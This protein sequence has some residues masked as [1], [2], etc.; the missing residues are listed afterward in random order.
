MA[1]RVTETEVKE[2][3]DTSVNT[4]AFITAANMVVNQNLQNQG[5]SNELLK[6]IER[7]LAAHFVAIRDPREQSK[8]VGSS[9]ANYQGQTGLGLDHTSYGQQVKVLDYTGTLG[10]LGF[11]RASIAVVS[12]KDSNYHYSGE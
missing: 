2:I 3:I 11:K 12:E 6:E 10:N 1:A 7:W 8:K 4:R 9:S 5:L